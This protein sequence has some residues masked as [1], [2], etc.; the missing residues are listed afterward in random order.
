M[1]PSEAQP[2]PLPF[3]PSIANYTSYNTPMSPAMRKNYIKDRVHVAVMYITEY[4]NTT[5]WSLENLAPL[6]KLTQHL[7][8]MFGRADAVRKAVDQA[9]KNDDKIRRKK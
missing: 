9:L 7:Q 6:H 2:L 4:G 3:I 8:I 5:L 1:D